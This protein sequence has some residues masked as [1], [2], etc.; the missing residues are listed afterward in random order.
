MRGEGN[1]RGEHGEMETGGGREGSR[2]GAKSPSERLLYVSQYLE[3]QHVSKT[4]SH[5]DLLHKSL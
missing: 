3:L 2:K 1:W 4:L 5:S